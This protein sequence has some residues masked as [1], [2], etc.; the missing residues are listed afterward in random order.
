MSALQSLT[1]VNRTR[2]VQPNSVAS[3]PQE[4]NEGCFQQA[5][6]VAAF[7]KGLGN[8]GVLAVR[9]GREALFGR[10]GQVRIVFRKAG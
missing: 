3:D 8:L 7:G 9:R 4:P 5:R 10:R 2:C 6:G 1:G